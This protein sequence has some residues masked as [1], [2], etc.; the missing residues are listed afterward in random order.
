MALLL[1]SCVVLGRMCACV[2]VCT[3][4]GVSLSGLGGVHF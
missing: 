4:S 3:L 1:T 2:C